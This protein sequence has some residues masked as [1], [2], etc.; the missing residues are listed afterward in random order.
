MEI[1]DE[2][3][4]LQFDESHLYLS[5]VLVDVGLK[6]IKE[7]I[8]KGIN[9]VVNGIQKGKDYTIFVKAS[10]YHVD[11]KKYKGLKDDKVYK[12]FKKCVKEEYKKIK[13][14]EVKQLFEDKLGDFLPKSYL[15]KNQ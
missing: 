14:P 1:D 6:E 10:H 2:D 12:F 4:I 8:G 5:Y 13:N 15:N 11:G 9:S 7:N 3:I